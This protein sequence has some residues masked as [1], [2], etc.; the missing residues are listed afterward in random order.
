MVNHVFI[1]IL[2]DFRVLYTSV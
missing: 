2:E 1:G